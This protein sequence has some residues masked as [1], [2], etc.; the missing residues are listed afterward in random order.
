MK[1]IQ[2]ELDLGDLGTVTAEI[3]FHWHPGQ[4]GRLAAVP[5]PSY[6]ME[7][8]EPHLEGIERVVLSNFPLC[9]DLDVTNWVNESEYAT[10]QVEDTV[11][12]FMKDTPEDA[13]EVS[14]E[15]V[16]DTET[17]TRY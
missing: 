10:A 9:D 3:Y 2:E 4:K 14:D 8:I 15:M 5:D 6:D 17:F 16:E 1:V 13:E 11:K 12:R 7:H